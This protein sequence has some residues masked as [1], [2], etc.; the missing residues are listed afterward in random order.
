MCS[1]SCPRTPRPAYDGYK[2][3]GL[4]GSMLWYRWHRGEAGAYHAT[5]R[6]G[7]PHKPACVF[8]SI[9]D[10]ALQPGH[11]FVS[12]QSIHL[13]T[14]CMRYPWRPR[15]AT[16]SSRRR[17]ARRSGTYVICVQALRWDTRTSG[18]VMG[19]RQSTSH[20]RFPS[21]HAAKPAIEGVAG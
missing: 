1:V 18:Q 9:E 20:P 8:A 7:S 4:E 3:D 5:P 11:A 16:R 13:C 17:T 2:F 15:D 14:H 10:A 6:A 21:N 19:H 12:R